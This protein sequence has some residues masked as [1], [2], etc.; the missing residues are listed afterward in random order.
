MKKKLS[1]KFSMFVLK[2]KY[3]NINRNENKLIIKNF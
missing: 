3:K 2:P 1:K